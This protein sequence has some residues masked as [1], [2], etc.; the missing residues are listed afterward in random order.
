MKNLLSKMLPS[1]AIRKAPQMY[2]HY[3]SSGRITEF[4]N[5][6]IIGLTALI[7]YYNYERI[8]IARYNAGATNKILQE[9]EK[10]KNKEVSQNGI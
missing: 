5:W 8:L 2:N 7:A 4:Q 10:I 1:L 3:N 6:V 9:M